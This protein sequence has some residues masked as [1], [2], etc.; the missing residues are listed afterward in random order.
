MIDSKQQKVMVVD[1]SKN[2][3]DLVKEILEGA[4]YKVIP[5]K[6]GKECLTLIRKRKVDLILLDVMMPD[7]HGRAV[8]KEI[9]KIDQ[10]VKVA[11]LTVL[12]YES[13]FL[14]KFSQRFQASRD[15]KDLKNIGISDFIQKPFT[16]DELISRVD[17]ILGQEA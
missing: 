13:S 11:I 7:M 5:A 2:T 4:G 14:D 15:P 1:D 3:R 12:E 9:R 10:K 6:N 17:K 16:S 8:Y